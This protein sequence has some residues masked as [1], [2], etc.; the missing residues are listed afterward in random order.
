ME[1]NSINSSIAGADPF[2]RAPQ[3][4]LP[5]SLSPSAEASGVSGNAAKAAEV[6][7]AP[8]RTGQGAVPVDERAVRESV[9]KL[10]AFIRP[11]VTSLQF[12]IDKDLGKVVIKVMDTETKEVI[13]QIPSEAVL[14]LA[15]ALG[16]VEG[17]LVEQK[18]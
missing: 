3:A 18:A 9:D 2:W 4:P 10:N 11:Y 5:S 6:A 12:S 7:R 8:E 1:I 17:L 14:E 15:K 13:K 16:K